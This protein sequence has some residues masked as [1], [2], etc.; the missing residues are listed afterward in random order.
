MRVT[1][2]IPII[3]S[4]RVPARRVN[5]QTIVKKDQNHERDQKAERFRLAE[6]EP[7]IRDWVYGRPGR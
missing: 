4:A 7:S 1:P 3:P 6:P 2:I 5:P